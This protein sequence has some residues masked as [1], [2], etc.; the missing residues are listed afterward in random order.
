MTDH[1]KL[2][3]GFDFDKV[4]VDYPPF[5]PTVIIDR[6]YKKQNTTLSYRFPHL[7]EQKIRILSHHR[8]FRPPIKHNIESLKKMSNDKNFELYLISG[9]FG[10]LKTQTQRWIEFYEFDKFFKNLY[11]NFDNRQPHEFK[12]AMIQKLK[13]DKY[14]DD[15]LDTLR[16]LS[17]QNPKIEFYWLIKKSFFLSQ[18]LPH[19]VI[20]V[21]NIEELRLKY[22]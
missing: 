4:F 13:I 7:F 18:S 6:L 20:P 22:L 1:K 8:L 2:K 17:E 11:F 9:R 19:N 3:I 16:F 12:N 15:D 5:I 21:N 14:I 10:F